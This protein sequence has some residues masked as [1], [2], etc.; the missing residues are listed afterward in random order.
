[1]YQIIKGYHRNDRLRHSFNELAEK[2]FGLNFEDWYRNGFW[3]E[4][5]TP[6]SAVTDGKIIANVSVNRTD[7]WHNGKIRHFLQ[8][9][10]VMTEEK[11][12]K[13]GLIRRIMEE[14]ERDTAGKAD[15]IYLFANDSVLD[16]YPK[17]GFRKSSEYQYGA[18]VSNT[19]K[20][21]LEKVLMDSPA[22]WERLKNA[23]ERNSFRGKLDLAH[24]PG[25][26]MFYATKFMRENVYFHK[27][28]DTY[29]I[30]ETE[31]GCLFLHSIYSGQLKETGPV[32]ELFGDGIQEVVLGFTPLDG[33]EYEVSKIREEDCTCFV[34]G[35]GLQILERE[36]LRIPSLAHA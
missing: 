13:Q 30:A 12:R 20:C 19:G 23:I 28:T 21:R 26:V 29:V 32:I 14:I 9:G 36:K 31:G 10:T 4:D 33:E 24:N 34:K 11:Y 35:E 27:P 6:Y 7:F 16:F 5:Y 2:T 15:G 22:A 18:K 25:L 1:M 3:G 17:F 8:L